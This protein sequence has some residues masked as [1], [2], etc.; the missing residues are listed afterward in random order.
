[1][2]A[3]RDP[4]RPLRAF[5]THQELHRY[6]IIGIVTDAVI[7]GAHVHPWLPLFLQDLAII[8]PLTAREENGFIKDDNMFSV[9]DQT[10]M[11]CSK[12]KHLIIFLC[13]REGKK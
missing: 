3:E 1:M 5:R 2:L 4:V 11:L 12:L 13:T 7:D 9:K 6:K 10:L 8:N